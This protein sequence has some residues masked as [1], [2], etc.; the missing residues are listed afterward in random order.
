MPLF[1]LKPASVVGS[2]VPPTTVSPS[3]LA[4][5]RDLNCGALGSDRDHSK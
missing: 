5:L 2:L 3:K 1:W 4:Y